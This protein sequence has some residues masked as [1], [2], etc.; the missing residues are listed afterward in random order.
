MSEKHSADDQAPVFLLI[1]QSRA[2]LRLATDGAK[3]R[4]QR[5]SDPVRWAKL[6]DMLRLCTNSLDQATEMFLDRQEGER[7]E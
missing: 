7:D 6:A 3:C 1:R 5:S 2:R 4:S